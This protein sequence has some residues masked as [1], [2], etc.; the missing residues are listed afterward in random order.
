[1]MKCYF[2][3]THFSRKLAKFRN[4]TLKCDPLTL[5]TTSGAVENDTVELAVLKDPLYRS[6][7]RISIPPRSHFSPGL[8]LILQTR[9]TNPEVEMFQSFSKGVLCLAVNNTAVWWWNVVLGQLNSAESSLSDDTSDG[10]GVILLHT[11][12]LDST[13]R[14]RLRLRWHQNDRHCTSSFLY[15]VII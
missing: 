2:W 6:R 4:L 12:C 8:E 15:L 5:K 13:K 9:V 14:H 7:D 3:P 1:M 11:S 10:L